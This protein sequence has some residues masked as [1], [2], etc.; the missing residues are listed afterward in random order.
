[1]DA[2]GT[3]PNDPVNLKRR[4]AWE[5]AMMDYN[6][7]K[8][9]YN[10]SPDKQNFQAKQREQLASMPPVRYAASFE[11][12]IRNRFPNFGQTSSPAFFTDERGNSVN[13]DFAPPPPPRY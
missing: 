1:M 8:A 2:Y 3:S 12:G 6:S 9:L 5:K 11:R 10:E 4:Q 7:D 13:R